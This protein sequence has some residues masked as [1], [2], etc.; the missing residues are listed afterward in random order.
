[1]NKTEKSE[2]ER[3]LAAGTDAH[4]VPLPILSVQPVEPAA[5]TTS[6]V[7]LGITPEQKL[8]SNKTLAKTLHAKRLSKDGVGPALSDT[9]LPSEPSSP[10][11]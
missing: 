4:V 5:S 1:M 10:K 11:M 3:K 9:P 6:S 8:D 2:Q 7:S